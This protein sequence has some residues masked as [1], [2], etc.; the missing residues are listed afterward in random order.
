[1]A[2]SLNEVEDFQTSEDLQ[3]S[4]RAEKLPSGREK[5]AFGLK[6]FV[7]PISRN[8]SPRPISAP[9]ASFGRKN[10]LGLKFFPAELPG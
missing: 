10:Y 5:I 3:L 4:Q 8:F 9:S 1:M 6:T 2:V 7:Q